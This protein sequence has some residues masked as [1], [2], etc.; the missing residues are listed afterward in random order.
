[1]ENIYRNYMCGNLN[2]KNVG[3]V[4]RLSRMGTKNK[5]FRCY[6]IYRFKR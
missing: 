1:M 3:E 2:I 5:K 6:E 4:V